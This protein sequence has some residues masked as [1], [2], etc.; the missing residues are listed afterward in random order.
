MGIL[1]LLSL[2]VVS[3][4]VLVVLNLIIMKFTKPH[5]DY[6]VL[7]LSLSVVL[8]CFAGFLRLIN[9]F[10]DIVPTAFIDGAIYAVAIPLLLAFGGVFSEEEEE[11]EV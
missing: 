7:T 9:V 4:T 5:L 2:V 11:E 8:P 6:R 3:A 1:L 10:G